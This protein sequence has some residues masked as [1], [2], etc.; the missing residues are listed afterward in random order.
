MKLKS[1][2]LLF[3]LIIILTCNIL[4][5]QSNRKP[6][7]NDTTYMLTYDH[8][9][10]ILWGS[11]H[12]RE[13]L[14]NAIE[15][16]DKYKSFKIGLDNE[17]YIYD[18]FAENEPALL[19][20]L[21]GYLIK[22][23]GRF[24]I[25]SSTYGQPLSQFINDESNIRQFSYALEAEKKYLNYRPPVY[26]MSEHAMHSQIPQI[27]KGFGY[28]GAIMRTHYMMYG[29]NP[30][31]DV[32]IGNWKGL[33]GSE[34]PAIPT[35]NGEGAAF[36]KTTID[37]W[38]L[39]RYPGK[40]SPEPMESFRKKF[41]K[42]NPLLASRADDSG[43]RKE[44]LVKEYD[45]KPKFSWILL[46]ELLS[47]YP[48]PTELMTT[49][50]NDFTVRMPWGYCGNE[51]WNSSRRAENS[52]LAAERL[53]AFEMMY[54]GESHEKDLDIA[55]KNL[56]LAQHHD[57]QICGLLPDARRLLPESVENSEHVI[58]ASM[59]FFAKNMSAVGIKQITVF[60]PLSWK[61]TKWIVTDIDIS[62][63]K[64]KNYIARCG[65]TEIP[66][67]I[68]SPNIAT[69]GSNIEV[70]GAFMAVLD[71]LSINSYSIIGVDKNAESE[72]TGI[73]TDER[74]L[75]VTTRFYE[76]ILSEDGG[77][78]SIKDVRTGRPITA[79]RNRS[80]F[81]E[82]TIED[83]DCQSSGKWIIQKSAENTP[84]VKLVE[85]GFISDIPYEFVMTLYDDNPRID[86]RV[87]FDFNGQRIGLL[88]EDKRD[89][90]SPF[91][92][93][94]KLRFKIFPNTDTASFG[95]RDL[96][97][98]IAE[99][100]NKYVEGNYWTAM[101]DGRSGIAYFNKGNMGSV[102]ENDN[103]FSIPLAYSMYYIWGTRM[104]Y[105]SYDYEFAILPFQGD[106]KSADLHRK[107]LEYNLP[108][109]VF[110]SSPNNGKL[111]QKISPFTINGDKDVLLTA[112]Y[113][114]NGKLVAR[115]FKDD[116]T[117]NIS[118]I[119]L[120]VKDANISE[121]RMDGLYLK[122]ASGKISF[123]PWEIKTFQIR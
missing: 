25:G 92:H 100:K 9:G 70:K 78:N 111:G 3:T 79:G 114:K 40:D 29:Y 49:M 61:Q 112:L 116:D 37:T 17:A 14:Q 76:I 38:I 67:K 47:K 104:L 99:T 4:Q 83:R 10:L 94:N 55:W 64:P 42:I 103:S 34:I 56:L 50:P 31:F 82:A 121:T 115:F 59:E 122:E 6:A 8:G 85:H 60:N 45:K 15:W 54:K 110:E 36:G 120:N 27:L 95:I 106:W 84:W 22:Y 5:G 91:V 33:D 19:D 107:A 88:S 72:K 75:S 69:D 48:A 13:R 44:E 1:N 30:T 26:L 87:S 35:Y 51:I 109:P 11:D 63:G 96:P 28:D 71:P 102:R 117:N 53:A 90:H 23:K 105:G 43:L 98:A 81:L 119:N 68:I 86:C 89:S 12:F 77:I 7:L 2:L 32:P 123:K 66:V 20:E 108:V 93:E 52:V 118:S 101:S 16:L 46:D 65:D 41:K 97:F 62:G 80:S 74:N 58:K 73:K 24:G 57:I 39:T 113:P 21:K 18:Y